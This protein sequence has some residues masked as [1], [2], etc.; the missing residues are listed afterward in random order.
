MTVKAEVESPSYQFYKGRK[1]IEAIEVQALLRLQEKV[2]PLLAVSYHTSGR[3]IFW[4][5]HNKREHLLRDYKLAK[6][7]AQLTEI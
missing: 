6:K 1:P 3:E 7:T 4:Y 5:Y 2:K